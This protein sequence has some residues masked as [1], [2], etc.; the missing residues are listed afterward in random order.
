MG[1]E[2]LKSEVIT[3]SMSHVKPYT[4]TIASYEDKY[5]ILVSI[6][7]SARDPVKNFP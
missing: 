1:T 5:G 3:E 6:Y 2:S 4:E 7:L